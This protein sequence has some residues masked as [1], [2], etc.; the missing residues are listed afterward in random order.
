MTAT[1]IIKS[2][3]G[4][5]RLLGELVARMPPRFGRYFEPFAGGA[6]LFFR[7]APRRAVLNDANED[8]IRLYRAVAADV[9]AVIVRLEEHRAAHRAHGAQHYHAVRDRWNGRRSSARRSP[10]SA[11]RSRRRPEGSCSP[12]RHDV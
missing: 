2:A 4:K 9:E 12:E 11:R 5:T 3:G 7:V 1:P 10:R 6:A 8:L